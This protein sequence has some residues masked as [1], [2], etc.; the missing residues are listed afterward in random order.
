MP[1]RINQKGLR[2]KSIKKNCERLMK[3]ELTYLSV[4]YV[5]VGK[6]NEK[7]ENHGS[8]RKKRDQLQF[9]MTEKVGKKKRASSRNQTE[10]ESKS[11]RKAEAEAAEDGTTI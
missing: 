6:K 1:E 9:Q 3:H 2:E 5:V 10:Q 7:L 8:L 11:K 4:F